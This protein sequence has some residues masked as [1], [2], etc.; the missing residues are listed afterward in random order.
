V[1]GATLTPISNQ[2]FYKLFPKSLIHRLLID[3]VEIHLSEIGGT[4]NYITMPLIKLL[5]VTVSL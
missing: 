5:A 2:I 4:V 1:I 3:N